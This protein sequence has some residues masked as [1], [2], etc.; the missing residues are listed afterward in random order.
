MKLAVV[1]LLAGGVWVW[2]QMGPVGNAWRR[3][4]RRERRRMSWRKRWLVWA[5]GGFRCRACRCW[6][7]PGAALGEVR[8]LQIDHWYTPWSEGGSDCL[9]NL[10]PMCTA[11]NRAKGVTPG[12]VW[13]ERYRLRSPT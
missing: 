13:E 1:A 3:R 2:W 12:R 5:L 7:K 9:L 10:R 6:L 8:G 11:H 4:T